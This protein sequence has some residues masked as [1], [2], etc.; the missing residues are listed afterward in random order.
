MSCCSSLLSQ[1]RCPST[2]TGYALWPWGRQEMLL[3]LGLC[4]VHS[5]ACPNG[6]SGCWPRTCLCAFQRVDEL[7]K[8]PGDFLKRFVLA[9]SSKW[10]LMFG[11]ANRKMSS[12]PKNPPLQF[13]LFCK[14]IPLCFWWKRHPLLSSLSLQLLLPH[15]ASDSD[16]RA[17][18]SPLG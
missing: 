5:V 6:A 3:R 11:E 7:R 13:G 9:K 16:D 1:S 8:H 4:S 14:R 10:W 17:W 15:K 2:K 12:C 18:H